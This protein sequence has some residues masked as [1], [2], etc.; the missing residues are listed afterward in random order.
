[1]ICHLILGRLVGLGH[2]AIL[3]L[4]L[5]LGRRSLLLLYIGGLLR[6]LGYVLLLGLRLHACLHDGRLLLGWLSL[7]LLLYDLRLRLTSLRLDTGAYPLLLGLL[8]LSLLWLDLLLLGVPTSRVLLLVGL[9]SNY[10]LGLAWLLLGHLRVHLL[11]LGCLLLLGLCLQRRS[12]LGHLLHR[13]P[14][15][16]RRLS[17]LLHLLGLLSLGD[18]ARGVFFLPLLLLFI[19]GDALLDITLQVAAQVDRK[20]G[21]FEG[22]LITLITLGEFLDDLNDALGLLGGQAVDLADQV[23]PF[24]HS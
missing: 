10:L 1:M 9:L 22:H 5:V 16:R 24:F 23:V 8:R 15:C 18:A 13:R 2:G 21:Q 20:L 4:R 19:L 12:L 14:R 7:H 11:L 6:L 3:A 17:L